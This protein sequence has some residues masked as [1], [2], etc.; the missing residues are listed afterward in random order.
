MSIIILDTILDKDPDSTTSQRCTNLANTYHSQS[1]P[2]HTP[3]TFG[4][5][6]TGDIS[7]PQKLVVASAEVLVAYDS[8]NSRVRVTGT[9]GSTDW[10][11]LSISGQTLLYDDGS[12]QFSVIFRL[13][14]GTAI[15]ITVVAANNAT[16]EA[17]D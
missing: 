9:C 1:V 14:D 10:N 12:L 17:R 15:T 3:E 6:S 5:G 11:D 4:W 2:A 16:I 7:A 8:S 13:V